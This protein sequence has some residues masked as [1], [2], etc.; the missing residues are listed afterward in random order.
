MIGLQQTIK[1]NSVD[2]QTMVNDLSDWSTDVSNKEKVRKDKTMYGAAANSVGQAVR[3]AQPK[4]N[5]PLP[6]IRNRIDIRS[7]LAESQKQAP[8][9][10]KNKTA[11][12]ANV[13]NSLKRDTT[14]MPDYYKNWDKIAR[15]NDS[16][17]SGN[18]ND[19][20][21]ATRAKNPKYRDEGKST[22]ELFKPT[23]G[24]GPNTQ[25][26]VKGARQSVLSAAEESKLQGNAYFISLDY[27]KA[28]ECYTRCLKNIDS[29]KDAHLIPDSQEMKKLV[30]SNRSQAYL[31]L[32]A[33]A[34][35]YDD[36]NRAVLIDP[37]HVKSI[38]R[39]GT[40]AYYL[41]KIKQ[42]KI[43]FITALQLDPQNIGF[44][45]YIQ[46]TD[47]RLQ[48]LKSEAMEKIERRMM[49]TNLE[50]VGFDEHSCRVPITEL[51]LDK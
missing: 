9:S 36:A 29:A 41:G 44:L 25:I 24:A 47:Q 13:E 46:K 33:H 12:N 45:E 5:K 34:K 50:E 19:T 38:G 32:K 40:A 26:V 7:S 48:K 28:I 23:S 42:A 17:D 30:L 35:A 14:P 27:S 21:D 1:N 16:D 11:S 2:L 22:A 10:S 51:H 4:S 43:D 8:A 31:K 37:S 49:F 6:P 18:E 15:E 20:G 3:N 39:R